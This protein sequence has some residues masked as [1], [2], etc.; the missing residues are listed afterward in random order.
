VQ[1][2]DQP[3]PRGVETLE[4]LASTLSGRERQLAMAHADTL[5]LHVEH[6]SRRVVTQVV[7]LGEDLHVLA[8]VG[9]AAGGKRR[10]RHVGVRA[11]HAGHLAQPVVDA[12]AQSLQRGRIER[13]VGEQQ[14]PRP[15]VLGHC[16]AGERERSRQI[17]LPWAGI[18]PLQR[19]H[20]PGGVASQR[21]GYPDLGPGGDHHCAVGRSQGAQLGTGAVECGVEARALRILGGGPGHARRSVEHDGEGHGVAEPHL[22]SRVSERQAQQREHAEL[23]EPGEDASQPP[24]QPPCLALPG[25]TFP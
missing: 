8:V 2:R 12:R 4:D 20:Q 22:R 21:R 16:A 18:E 14:D 5:C 19:T 11:S 7:H 13:A 9:I 3:R 6:D 24:P 10:D 17:R 15:W 25:D 23:Q 1:P